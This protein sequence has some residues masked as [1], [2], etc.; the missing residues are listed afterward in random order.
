MSKPSATR[1][2]RDTHKTLKVKSSVKAGQKVRE[3]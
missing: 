2:L 1:L 3:A